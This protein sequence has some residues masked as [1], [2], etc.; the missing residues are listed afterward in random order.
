VGFLAFLLFIIKAIKLS[1][2]T[3]R[4]ENHFI[5]DWA[6]MT[7]SIITLV[8]I[9]AISVY[10]VNGSIMNFLMIYIAI[11]IGIKAH[12]SNSIFEFQDHD[13]ELSVPNGSV[14]SSHSF[15]EGKIPLK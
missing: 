9:I 1:A 5:S 14:N 15:R 8:M 12:C 4:D 7:S 11:M 13:V 2:S 6:I 10:I 3:C